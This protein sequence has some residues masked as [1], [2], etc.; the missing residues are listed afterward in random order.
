LQNFLLGRQEKKHEEDEEE[1]EIDISEY[2][3]SV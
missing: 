3:L 1:I 2:P